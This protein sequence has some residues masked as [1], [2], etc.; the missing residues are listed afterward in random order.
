[1]EVYVRNQ[2]KTCEVEGC[3]QAAVAKLMCRSHYQRNHRQGD[4]IQR[5]RP[6]RL[7][8]GVCSKCGESTVGNSYN[9][10][11][12]RCKRCRNDAQKDS[13]YFR[14]YG[15]TPEMYQEML[16]LQGGG[17]AICRKEPTPPRRRLCIDHDHQTG[18]VRG[19]I[20]NDCNRGLGLLGD[21]LKELMKTVRYLEES[22]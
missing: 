18:K 6:K 10:N 12:T 1:M 4:P 8:Q 3:E 7:P 20:C 11:R 22:M 15:V 9:S 17:C 14:K 16:D 5:P 19:L 2:G 13:L 21:N